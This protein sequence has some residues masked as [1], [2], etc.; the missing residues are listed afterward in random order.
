MSGLQQS[1]DWDTTN[2]MEPLLVEM[3]NIGK[4]CHAKFPS[5]AINYQKGHA[6]VFELIL[7]KGQRVQAWLDISQQY[8]SDRSC[9]RKKDTN[10]FINDYFV[11]AW[12]QISE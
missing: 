1:K 4:L 10:E 8:M 5:C 6:H 2:L 3:E 11:V 12:K 9:W 7:N